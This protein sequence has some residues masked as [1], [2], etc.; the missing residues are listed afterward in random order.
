MDPRFTG[1]SH[2]QPQ[3]W[4]KV[5]NRVSPRYDSGF[6]SLSLQ[7]GGVSMATEQAPP[8]PPT[9][10][11]GAAA[12]PEEQCESGVFS[13]NMGAFCGD[14]ADIDGRVHG[15]QQVPV[16]S[17]FA[18]NTVLPPSKELASMSIS[19]EPEVLRTVRMAKPVPVTTIAEKTKTSGRPRVRRPHRNYSNATIGSN[20]AR[21]STS[22]PPNSGGL[23]SLP[24]N[25]P[26]NL[27]NNNSG[28]FCD[29]RLP[30]SCD[31]GYGGSQPSSMSSMDNFSG[32]SAMNL[33]WPTIDIFE[34]QQN[35]Q[36]F[37]PNRDGDT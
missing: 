17:E 8:R 20:S 13:G 16:G 29:T 5:G 28:V 7:S 14:D 2:D 3:I 37:L 24:T 4:S 10:I 31:T 11:G 23:Q 12:I 15:D 22:S 1:N 9:L 30:Q 36:Y 33:T 19:R 27:G 34:L 6:G 21:S 18:V 32:N 25:H 26:A 35:V